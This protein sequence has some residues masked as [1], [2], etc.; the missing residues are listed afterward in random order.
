MKKILMLLAI[1]VLC[2]GG[3]V[4]AAEGPMLQT[5]GIIA[6]VED[7]KAIIKA[8]EPGKDVALYI[9]KAPY[10]I[11]KQTGSKLTVN[12]VKAG[13][14]VTAFY[15]PRLTKSIPPLGVA[16]LMVLGKGE[17]K[18]AYVRVSRSV[19]ADNKSVLLYYDDATIRIPDNVLPGCQEIRLGD[20]LL[21]WLNPGFNLPEGSM[22]GAVGKALML[23]RNLK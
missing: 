8:Y 22:D 4:S 10:F 18:V 21:V 11:D 12:D 15:A 1:C 9:G 6:G 19:P 5:T 16:S 20:Q 3:V 2:L 7:D 14:Q 13:L 23:N 17:E